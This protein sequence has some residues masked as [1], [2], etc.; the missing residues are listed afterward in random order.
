MMLISR[1]QI[2]AV[3]AVMLLV[4]TAGA[5]GGYLLGSAHVRQEA[6]ERVMEDAVRSEAFLN[7][8]VDESHSLLHTL[9][10]SNYPPCS[11]AEIAFF[12][13]L[14]FRAE[15]MRDAG[16]M[17]DGR[18]QCSAVFGREGLP[19]Q[20]FKPAHS[21]QDGIRIYVNLPPY[22]IV[23]AK[24]FVRQLGSFYVVEDPHFSVAF[25]RMR[26][27]RDITTTNI[28]RQPNGYPV[29]FTP[30]V[31]GAIVD[32]ESQGRIGDSLFATHCTPQ[33]YICMTSYASV[34]SALAAERPLL[35]L[36]SALG[37]LSGAF[38]VMVYIVLYQRNR[39]MSAQLRR[40]IRNDRLRLV[41]QPVVELA[42]RRIVG[43]EA[44]VR[45]TDE[46]GFVISP[47]IFVRAAEDLGFVDELTALVVR[48]ALR[49]F[50]GILR[51]Q[52]DFQLNINVTA[53][54]LGDI[55]FLPML[56]R[57]LSEA[58]VATRRFGIEVTESSTARKQIA[59]EAIHELRQ[60]GHSVL[61]DD[62]GTGYSSLAY[63]HDLD[64][65]A[66]KID[67]IF[68]HTIGTEAVTAGILPQILSMAATLDLLVVVEGIET[69]E[70]ANYFAGQE[71]QLLG[72]GWFFGRPVPAEE[73]LR[74]LDGQDHLVLAPA[75]E[76]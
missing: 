42:S 50:G 10:T 74:M 25:D 55:K 20:E 9:N 51:A 75:G 54:D 48:H 30:K 59:R 6:R 72:Q 8:L 63:L 41:Y 26:Q 71:R 73:F 56:K 12:R 7:S 2:W 76:I 17:A 27:G 64:A 3:A 35:A 23:D 16:R 11:D 31:P 39:G 1:K 14:M 53:S 66:I 22:T 60:R 52:T 24:V 65:G 69:E 44:L 62:F 61:I 68:T 38:L 45:W 57:A 29:G 67:R 33:N 47:E 19:K 21:F 32:R 15:R 13:Q 49:D 4:V 28:P 37:G 46:D 40:A 5:T 34:S 58:G 18:L 43:A 36:D 70:Q